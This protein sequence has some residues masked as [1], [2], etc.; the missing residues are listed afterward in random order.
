M[1]RRELPRQGVFT[2]RPRG[3][4]QKLWEGSGLLA[5]AEAQTQLWQSPLGHERP[6]LP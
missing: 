1:P 4:R 3:I 5:G 6:W 2:G